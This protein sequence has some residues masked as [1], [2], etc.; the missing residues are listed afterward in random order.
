MGNDKA[1]LK[2]WT[3]NRKLRPS[4]IA[5]R[6]P[7]PRHHKA[8]SLGGRGTGM[9]FALV[10]SAT[11][12]AAQ[13]RCP[14]LLFTFYSGSLSLLSLSGTPQAGPV[15]RAGEPR[16]KPSPC[17]R[18]VPA[19][20]ALGSCQPQSQR[21]GEGSCLQFFSLLRNKSHPE[22]QLCPK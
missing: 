7:H 6:G 12:K 22:S 16:R 1:T 4:W 15:E 11:E 18:T 21:E 10:G 5:S 13:G 19:A 20:C 9:S 8:Y 3:L 14:V 17:A 2:S